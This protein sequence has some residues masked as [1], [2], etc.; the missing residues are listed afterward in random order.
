MLES[1]SLKFTELTEPLRVPT[2]GV[3]IFVGPNNSG[4]EPGASEIQD[5]INSHARIETK[6]LNDVEIAR[7]TEDQLVNEIAELDRKAPSGSSPDN[8]VVSGFDQKG[9]VYRHA[10]NRA[11]LIRLMRDHSDKR[12][13]ASQFPR[14]FLIRLDGRTRF[15]LTNGEHVRAHCQLNALVS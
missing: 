13:I 15:E 8:V 5:E 10:L 6:I 14:M 11:S 12:W 3:T 7:M 1:I 9:S 2:Q 4:E